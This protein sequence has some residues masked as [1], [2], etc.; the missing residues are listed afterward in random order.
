MLKRQIQKNLVDFRSDTVTIPSPQ[1]IHAMSVAV[2]GD[3]V[4]G[5]DVSV[6]SLQ[7]ESSQLSGKESALFLVSGTMS[8][9]IAIQ[10]HLS[11]PPY[12]VVCDYKSHVYNYEAS[13][14]SFHTGAL[15]LPC[16]STA[17]EIEKVLVTDDDVHHAPTKLL[18][19]EN[20]LNGTIL[21][22]E[23]LKKISKL[24]K[25][26]N[27]PI[28]LDGARLWNASVATGI[29]INEYGKYV[30]SISLCFSK[31]LGCPI[32][33]VLV[34][35]TNFI[36]RAKHLRKM[37][38]G[39]WRQAG[40]LANACKFSLDNILPNL[41]RDHQVA[42]I[43]KKGLV[44]LGFSL[45]LPVETNMVWIDASSLLSKNVVEY[46]KSRGIIVSAPDEKTGEWRLV[47]HH[48]I[49]EENVS[50]FLDI[51]SILSKLNNV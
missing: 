48:Q 18:C 13:G 44:K 2:V 15:V 25:K 16:H 1:M 12:S 5:E 8:N 20:T 46:F 50:E 43:L 42:Q 26:H 36:K 4:Y 28:H 39:G 32:G 31:G 9:Q 38:G 49:S 34:G 10:A 29:S 51:L 45:L 17:L 24:A 19:L 40:Y 35:S 27:I 3:D 21:P 30:D 14:I 6:N 7:S 37:Y 33:S 47:I 23:E 41:Q 22:F 11:N